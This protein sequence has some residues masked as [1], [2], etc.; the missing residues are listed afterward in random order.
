VPQRDENRGKA[1]ILKRTFRGPGTK[2]CGFAH[3]AAG[4]NQQQR[5]PAVAYRY[6]FGGGVA[7]AF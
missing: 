2:N 5:I 7:S 6:A 4:D 1:A 3:E